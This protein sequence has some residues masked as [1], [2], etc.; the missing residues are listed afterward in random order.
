MLEEV[1]V[2]CKK[3]K[4]INEQLYLQK[5]QIKDISEIKGLENAS[6]LK[7][8]CLQWNTIK[9]IKGLDNLKNLEFLLLHYNQITE[10][11]GLDKLRNLKVLNLL[12]NRI[13]KIKGL[14]KLENLQILNLSQNSISKLDGLTNLKN[15]EQIYLNENYISEIQNLESLKNLKI[16]CLSDN[17]IPSDLL[18]K[19]GNLDLEGKANYPQKFVEYC[20]QMNNIVQFVLEPIPIAETSHDTVE[21]VRHKSIVVN[22]IENEQKIQQRIQPEKGNIKALLLKIPKLSKEHKYL[23]ALELLEKAKNLANECKLYEIATDIYVKTQDINFQRINFHIDDALNA[24]K[25]TTMCTF[26][27]IRDYLNSTLPD[28]NINEKKLKFKLLSRINFL[29]LKAIMHEDFIIFNEQALK[30]QSLANDISQPYDY[31]KKVCI[32][33]GEY[34]DSEAIICPFCGIY[35]QKS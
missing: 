9:E 12:G 33:C 31:R 20:D 21:N 19:L 15:L 24:F 34:I 35:Q 4:I 3:V 6:N 22:S 2:H 11:K 13:S 29:N 1:E 14:E 26:E 5:K 8:L 17:P 27:D 7:G 18:V 30:T 16:L 10:I 32:S 25:N 28:F 23:E